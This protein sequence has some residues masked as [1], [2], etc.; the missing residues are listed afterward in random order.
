MAQQHLDRLSAVD[1]GFLAQESPTTHMHIGGV[2]VLDGPPPPF[3]E[4]RAHVQSRLHLVPRYRQ[5][6]AHP[7]L[8][9][10]LPVWI[11]DP[12]FNLGYHLR[13]TGLP[14]PGGEEALLTHA[15]H[16]FSVPLDRDKPLWELWVVEGLDAGGWALVSKSH[17]ALVDGVGGIDISGVLLDLSPEGTPRPPADP[18]VPQPEPTG[19]QL[20]ALGVR[21]AVR[22]ASGLATGAVAEVA[23]PRR[24]GSRVR[25]VAEGIGAVARTALDPPS[26]TPFN[27]APGSHRRIAVVRAE[28][29]ELKAIK[30]V[31][32]GTVNDVVLAAVAGGLAH[33]LR[34]RGEE[35]SAL[36]LKACVPVSVR[37]ESSR[38]AGN[39]ITV[40]MAPLPV[41][42]A[43]PVARLARVREVMGGLKDSKQALGAK[44]IATAQDLAPA[45]LVAQ[46]SRLQFASRM[47]NL[48]VTNVPG[49]Q[50]PLYMLGRR[51]QTV[52]PVPFLAGDRA[53]AVAILSY[54]GH[55]DFG[56]LGDYDALPDLDVVAE[57][58]HG[59]LAE[60][61]AAA[62]RAE[63]TE[64]RKARRR[65]RSR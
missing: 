29:S 56:L 23:D 41:Q 39:A 17:H 35:P 64:A 36:E 22:R 24:F 37:D 15:S 33:F 46:A 38:H 11:D 60:L 45:G 20:A 26:P 63:R 10:G 1:V 2:V 48:L 14:K 42:I 3:E 52:I 4:I 8:Q 5:K 6:L 44:A 65:G 34:H 13:H 43:D 49:P 54:D 21:G 50:L 12:T 51:M 47:Y 28:L 58:I 32:G 55:M 40:M 7:P 19:V 30:T 57:G 62:D 59:A 25:E 27:V 53:L 31:L 18:W 61:R 16:V 9:S